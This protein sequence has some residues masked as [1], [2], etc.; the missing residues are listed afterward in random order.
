MAQV[1]STKSDDI[2]KKRIIVK[3]KSTKP[4]LSNAEKFELF[5]K[6]G[7]LTSMIQENGGGSKGKIVNEMPTKRVTTLIENS[8]TRGRQFHRRVI[9]ASREVTG[10]KTPSASAF[11]GQYAKVRYNGNAFGGFHMTDSDF[12]RKSNLS[13][14][15]Q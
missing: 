15:K 12:P 9:S 6:G 2:K 5:Q 4:K 14:R 11:R 8:P 3:K 10:Q 13:D 1:S 7:Q